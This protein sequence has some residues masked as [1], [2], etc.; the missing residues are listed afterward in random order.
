MDRFEFV[1]I[2]IAIVVGFAISEVFAGW[3]HQIRHGGLRRASLLHLVATAWILSYA[4]RFLW[5]Q[6]WARTAIGT[7]GEYLLAI[8]PAGLLALAAHVS[9]S[10]ESPPLPA[11]WDPYGRVRHA[12]CTLMALLSLSTL[13]RAF[14]LANATQSDAQTL[15]A[16][17]HGPRVVLFASMALVAD[18]RLQWAG[19]SIVW[20]GSLITV[21]TLAET[22][23]R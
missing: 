9:R 4:I 20:A 19:W 17:V 11:D 8:A 23:E 2:P 1:Q 13:A 15:L 7:Y 22:L 10:W 18:R 3:G 12:L 14:L 6:W 5:I 21:T 16:L